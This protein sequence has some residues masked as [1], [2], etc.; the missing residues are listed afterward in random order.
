M[1]SDAVIRELTAAVQRS[2]EAVELRL[3]LVDL[4]I[5][6]GSVTEALTHC[7]AALAQDASNAAALTLLHDDL[8]TVRR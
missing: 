3:H 1:A 4:L 7:S 6:Q 2:P 8:R 5:Q